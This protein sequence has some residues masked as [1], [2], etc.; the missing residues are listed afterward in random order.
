MFCSFVFVGLCVYP[1]SCNHW[2]QGGSE[3]ECVREVAI[4]CPKKK[5]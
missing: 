5:K 3:E 4:L 2:I 1:S